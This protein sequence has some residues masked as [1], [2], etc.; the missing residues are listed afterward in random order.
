MTIR[1]D[2]SKEEIEA[3]ATVLQAVQGQGLLK[4]LPNYIHIS[5]A[6]DVSDIFNRVKQETAKRAQT[7][8][9]YDKG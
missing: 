5:D 4:E 7:G 6:K 8:G 1:I 9:F 2:I 3:L